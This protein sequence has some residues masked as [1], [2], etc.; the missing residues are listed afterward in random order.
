MFQGFAGDGDHLLTGV[1]SP[2]L[3]PSTTRYKQCSGAS[4]GASPIVQA[5]HRRGAPQGTTGFL[6]PPAPWIKTRLHCILIIPSLKLSVPYY[7][8]KKQNKQFKG[9]QSFP[10][11]LS[12][13]FPII[14]KARSVLGTSSVA[15]F[16][17][18][19]WSLTTRWSLCLFGSLLYKKKDLC[20]TMKML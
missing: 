5:H 14:I 6:A 13:S 17:G 18:P 4:G 7:R 15:S 16:Q 2:V 3:S 19:R 11:F 8:E 1:S 12:L 10:F 20:T 9:A